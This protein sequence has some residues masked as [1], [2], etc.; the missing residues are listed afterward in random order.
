MFAP[1]GFFRGLSD[2]QLAT[3]AQAGNWSSADIPT[4]D[5]AC[6][7]RSWYCGPPE[8]MIEYL[9]ELEETFPGLEAVNVQS[10]MGTPES[11]LI[12]QLERFAA[13][14]MPAFNVER[15]QSSAA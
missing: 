4:I 1:L 11:V 2:E 6:G 8:G 13:E 5:Q 14:V 3:V 15:R 10:S 9:K 7:A 12:E